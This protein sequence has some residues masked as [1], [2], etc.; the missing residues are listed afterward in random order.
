MRELTGSQTPVE[1]WARLNR[2]LGADK[3]YLLRP[4]GG[5]IPDI[6]WPVVLE[7]KRFVNAWV[8]CDFQAL[9]SLDPVSLDSETAMLLSGQLPFGGEGER[10]PG[11]LTLLDKQFPYLFHVENGTISRDA[12]SVEI[13][14]VPLK[15]WIWSPRSGSLRFFGDWQ[16]DEPGTLSAVGPDAGTQTRYLTEEDRLEIAFAVPA[17]R[18]F[19]QLQCIGGSGKKML[20]GVRVQLVDPSHN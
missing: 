15:F 16:A 5:R 2:Q 6:L 9:R 20:R 13:G 1:N 4:D 11:N 17:G 14:A 7:R 10:L 19:F 18:S 3:I 12:S 8:G